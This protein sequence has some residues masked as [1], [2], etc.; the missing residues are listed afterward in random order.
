[1]SHYHGLKIYATKEILLYL[2]VYA[3]EHNIRYEFDMRFTASEQC[4]I[5]KIV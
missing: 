1:M 2:A 4:A 5:K 3:N